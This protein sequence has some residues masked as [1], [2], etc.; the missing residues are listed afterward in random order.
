MAQQALQNDTHAL[1]ARR[2]GRLWWSG[3]CTGLG[4]AVG[5]V[6]VRVEDQSLRSVHWR[7]QRSRQ[8]GRYGHSCACAKLSRHVTGQFAVGFLDVDVAGL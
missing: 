5:S 1:S 8:R 4:G 3:H 7:E 6:L 2:R